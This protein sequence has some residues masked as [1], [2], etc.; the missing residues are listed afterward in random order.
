MSR[1]NKNNKKKPVKNQSLSERLAQRWNDGK[2]D[3]FISLYMRNRAASDR[4]KQAPRLTDAYYNCLAQTMFVYKDIEGAFAVASMMILE[5]NLG[6]DDAR[7]RGCARLVMDI[8]GLKNGER[9]SLSELPD[10]TELPE[11]FGTTRLKIREALSTA[12]KGKKSIFA[13]RKDPLPGKLE[14]QFDA[15]RNAKTVSPYSTFLNIA[16]KLESKT[17]NMASAGTFKALRAIASLLCDIIR[18]DKRGVLREPR[19]V[20][21]HP[22]FGEILW[23]QNHASV[24]ALWNYLCETGGK[25][26]GSEWESAVR[27]MQVKFSR[28][29]FGYAKTYDRLLNLPDDGNYEYL[30]FWILLNYDGWTEHERYIMSYLAIHALS[31]RDPD[32]FLKLKT[33]AHI[34]LFKTLGDIGRKWRPENPWPEPVKN[35]FKMLCSENGFDFVGH[36]IKANLPYEAMTPSTLVFISLYSPEVLSVI[37]DKAS[38]LLPLRLSQDETENVASFFTSPVVPVG[39]MRLVSSL[40]DKESL[41][42]TLRCLIDYLVTMS[43]ASLSDGA[44]LREMPWNE[45]SNG[46]IEFFAEN[47]P[48]DDQ[49]GCFCRLCRGMKRYRLS[50]DAA[51]TE[52]FFAAKRSYDGVFGLLLSFFLMVWPD[53]SPQ[54]IVKL[55][56]LSIKDNAAIFHPDMLMFVKNIPT[57]A[58]RREVASGMSLALA[59]HLTPGAYRM[60]KSAIRKLDSY[61]KKHQPKTRPADPAQKTLFTDEPE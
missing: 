26:Y 19:D 23:P 32:F 57:E 21:R 16:E 52:A 42:E 3:A 49:I 8:A 25:K 56:E 60:F 1:K 14:K 47:L 33:E 13:S 31:T 30:P 6:A 43:V 36:I 40:L 5:E 48:E 34:T 27:V 29:Q 61:N 17:A 50:G 51:A 10:D 44:A 41:A 38:R 54:F 2:W 4:T 45:L 22:A 55:F 12:K 20:I 46:H 24:F 37:K 58:S 35:A 39:V 28:V 53:I 59:K 18:P 7:L 9:D 15:L 11:P